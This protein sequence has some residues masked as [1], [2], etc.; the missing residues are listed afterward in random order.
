MGD[1]LGK[2]G[3]DWHVALANLVN[4]LI[5]L[6]VLKKFAFG[7]IGK[8]INE[9]KQKI[10]EG[11]DNAK[12]AEAELST[13]N[14]TKDE[15]LREA[16]NSSNKIVATSQADAKEIVKEAKDKATSEREEIIR[17]AKL[18][19]E[20]EKKSSEEMVRKET[21]SLVS[22]SVKKIVEGY[23][24]KGKGDEIINAMLVK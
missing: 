17:Q 20:K 19:A 22:E 3:F 15:I 16:R 8:M 5:I 24:A 14:T 4:F 13:A 21:A 18:D 9:R 6:F 12:K 23:V 2:I 10:Q 11:L 1:I 7:P